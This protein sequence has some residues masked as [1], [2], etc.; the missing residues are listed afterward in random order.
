MFFCELLEM[1]ARTS[2]YVYRRRLL[3]AR[4]LLMPAYVEA[5]KEY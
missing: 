5:L 2:C 1:K 4:A 3:V